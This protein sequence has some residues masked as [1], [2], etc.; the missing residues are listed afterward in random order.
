VR[1]QVFAHKQTADTEDANMLLRK[2]N[3]EE[4]KSLF[5]FLSALYSAFWELFHHGRE[6]MLDVRDW[7][8][9][10]DDPPRGREMLPGERVYR[11]GQEALLSMLG[12]QA[13]E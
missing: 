4:M 12:G 3:V 8:L 1:H 10:P 11:G 6:P 13:K 7:I 5:A 9:P 2:T